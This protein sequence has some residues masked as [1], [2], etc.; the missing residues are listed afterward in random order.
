VELKHYL[1]MI[2][3]KMWLVLTIV[4]IALAATGV[5]SFFFTTPVYV[6]QAK[7]IVNQSAEQAGVQMPSVG[8][9]QSSIMMINSYKEIIKSAAIMTKVAAQY[10][11][12]GIPP[13]AM[14]AAVMVGSAK[15]SQVMTLTYT[16]TSYA[17]AAQTVNAIASVFEKEI[18][19]IMKIDNVT[20][21]DEANPERNA[22]PIN[23]NPIVSI[24]ISLVVSTML[25]VG[26]IFLLDYLD[27]TIKSEPELESLLGLPVLTVVPHIGKQDLR[28]SKQSKEQRSEISEGRYAPINH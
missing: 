28:K 13:E 23:G 24:L 4:V 12:L 10:P 1:R 16:H 20:I 8:L 2:K 5:K 9:M 22:A 21:L 11:E 7:L 17:K 19:L 18:P 25:A 26:L 27:D 15:D 14:S 6:A 3:K